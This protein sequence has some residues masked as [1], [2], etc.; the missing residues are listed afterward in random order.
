MLDHHRETIQRLVAVL[1]DDPRYR[2]LIVGGSIAKGRET[3]TS[4]VDILLV[5]TDDEF[6]RRVQDVDLWYSN[7]EVADYPGGYVDGHVIDHQFLIDVADHGSE[8]ARA[9]FV[10]AFAPYARIPDLDALLARIPVYP[11]HE[12]V[13]KITAFYSQLALLKGFVREGKERGDHYLLSWAATD[14]VFYGGRLILAHNRILYP[15]RKWLMHEV[16]H[17]P[18][19]PDDFMSLADRLLARPNAET[20]T[21]LW[22]CIVSFRDWGVS[23]ETAVSQFILDVEWGWREGHAPLAER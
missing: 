5:A 12:R 21:A 10:G 3:P 15:W 9:A 11:E 17:A 18:D 20:A 23:I 2:A 13:A 16:A 4:D 7:R 22:D 8:P 6:R 14:M 19:K 1:E